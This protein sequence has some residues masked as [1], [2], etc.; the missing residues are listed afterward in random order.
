V[1]QLD[2]PNFKGLLVI[3]SFRPDALFTQAQQSRLSELMALWCNARDQ[4]EEILPEQQAEL[5]RLVELE[6]EAATARTTA[7]VEQLNE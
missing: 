4:G 1:A 2:E 6:L 7:L 3:Q 5:D